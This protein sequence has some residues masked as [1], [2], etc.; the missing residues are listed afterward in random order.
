MPT[1]RVLIVA[2][3]V[4]ARFGG[5]AFLPLHYFSRLLARGVDAFLLTHE[6]VMSELSDLFP[7]HLH[8]M[9]FIKE[10]TLTWSLWKVGNAMPPTLRQVSVDAFRNAIADAELRRQ[11]KLIV[12]EKHID[13]VH[14]PIPVSPRRP[15]ALYDIGA[16]VVIGPMNGN[17]NFPPAFGAFRGKVEGWA[18]AVGRR[19]TEWTNRMSP[20]KIKAKAL[21]VSNGRTKEGL[22][23]CTRH[24]P[25]IE[26]VENGVDLDRF[27]YRQRP[28]P[29][30][31]RF[32]FVGRLVDWKAVDILVEAF[33]ALPRVPEARLDLIGDGDQRQA[34]EKQ[35]EILGI[36]DR[37]TFHG[38]LPQDELARFLD[39]CHALVLPSLYEC[40]GAVV[41][42]AMAK[43]IP[44]IA[45]DWG[46]PAD[47]LD[48]DCGVL[49]APTNRANMVAGFKRAMQDFLETPAK[50]N[51]LGAAGRR[52]VEAEY[53]W[54]RKIDRILEIYDQARA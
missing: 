25:V 52:K 51:Q 19:A 34:L 44:A 35:V 36:S 46:G 42:E 30:T 10:T 27:K 23:I 15:S 14:Q 20:G 2:E 7:E 41:L 5:E 6:R 39:I 53:D 37:V 40:G 26:L 11:A 17:M 4:S 24:V 31:I 9:T 22:P 47:Y 28:D 13:I 45:T 18:L 16:P 38:F 29:D 33:A 54:E 50:L 43:G 21:I 8:R 3:N 48:Q 32:V 1:P 49:V 12:A